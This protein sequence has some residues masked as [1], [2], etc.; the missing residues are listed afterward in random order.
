MAVLGFEDYAC[1]GVDYEDF[2]DYYT[3][4]SLRL[5]AAVRDQPNYLI[6][7]LEVV[8]LQNA[9]DMVYESV[10]LLEDLENVFFVTVANVCQHPGRFELE[11]SDQLALSIVQ[12]QNLA[13]NVEYVGLGQD[14]LQVGCHFMSRKLLADFGDHCKLL[15]LGQILL[16]DERIQ[17]ELNLLALNNTVVIL[18]GKWTYV[19]EVTILGL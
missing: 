18:R 8:S 4:D 15:D 17:Q 10:L 19:V 16:L 9:V 7:H 5:A 13:Q 3:V 14:S 12:A 1:Q 2:S 6:N 11:E